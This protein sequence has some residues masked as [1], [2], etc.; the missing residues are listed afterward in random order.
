[1]PR[2]KYILKTS[3]G[4]PI[5]KVRP[6]FG[7]PKGKNAN[8]LPR[9]HISD[10]EWPG[11]IKATIK[12]WKRIFALKAVIIHSP[13]AAAPIRAQTPDRIVPSR[14]VYRWKPGDGLGAD[15]IEKVRWCVQWQHDPDL[16]DIRRRSPTPQTSSIKTF[17]QVGASLER[18]VS[19]ADVATAFMQTSETIS[20]HDRPVNSTL[21]CHQVAFHFET[22]DG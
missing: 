11:F 5:P 1:M 21:S 18:K 14:H 2:Q 19:I 7:P 17:L 15:A 16:F 22:A 6:G 20:A 8:E 3:F 9:S 12:E 4:I 13:K 10:G